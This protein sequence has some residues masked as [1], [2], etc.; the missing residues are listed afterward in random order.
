MVYAGQY[1]LIKGNAIKVFVALCFTVV[2]LG[3]F[4]INGYVDW[5]IGLTLAI[6]SGLGAMVASRLAVRRGEKFVR[7]VLLIAIIMGATKLLGV[8]FA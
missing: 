4:L 8:A 7:W 1:D 6:G 2:A 3:V 5:K